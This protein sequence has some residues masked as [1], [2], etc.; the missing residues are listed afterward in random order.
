MSTVDIGMVWYGVLLLGYTL[1][2][3]Q[4]KTKPNGLA[5]FAAATMVAKKVLSVVQSVI[6][7]V[8]S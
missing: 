3:H 2:S 5:Y 1:T 7:T 4:N 8:N 6:R